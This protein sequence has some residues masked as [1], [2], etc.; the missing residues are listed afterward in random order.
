MCRIVCF[1]YKSNYRLVFSISNDFSCS[2]IFVLDQYPDRYTD[3]PYSSKKLKF[4]QLQVELFNDFHMRLCQIREEAKTPL[5]RNYL[6]VLNTANYI[7]YILEEW[8]YNPVCSIGLN[9]LHSAMSSF[10]VYSSI[11]I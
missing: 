5:S 11:V 7:I 2:Q 9:S 10:N 4:F 6:G 3:L 8:K 1:A